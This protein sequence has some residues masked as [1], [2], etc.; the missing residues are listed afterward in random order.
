MLHC[1][2]LCGCFGA[3]CIIHSAEQLTRTFEM[4]FQ[5]RNG[6]DD[7]FLVKRAKT[8]RFEKSSIISMQKF[9]NNEA[10]NDRY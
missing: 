8:D 7:L 5:E 1:F 2:I 6:D 3:M 9:L 4:L 10:N